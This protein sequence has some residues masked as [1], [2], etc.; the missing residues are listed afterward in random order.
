[1]NFRNLPAYCLAHMCKNFTQQPKN[2]VCHYGA[3]CS[4]F[5]KKYGVTPVEILKRGG[6]DNVEN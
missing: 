6:V 2:T 4:R 5:V 3:L 1:M